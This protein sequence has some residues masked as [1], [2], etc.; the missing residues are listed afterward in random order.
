MRKKYLNEFLMM[1]RTENLGIAVYAF[2]SIIAC[3]FGQK[4][5]D[6]TGNK[7]NIHGFFIFHV[8][9]CLLA[10]GYILSFPHFILEIKLRCR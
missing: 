2:T 8:K 10:Q 1:T 7:L 3:N 6:E 4:A 9:I 5:F